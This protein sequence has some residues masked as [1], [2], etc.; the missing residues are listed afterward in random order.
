MSCG[1]TC[2]IYW[3]PCDTISTNHMHGFRDEGLQSKMFHRLY[4]NNTLTV[5]FY[6]TVG[7]TINH[8]KG[9]LVTV[10]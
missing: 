3:P 6:N 5:S 7:F 10:Y 2:E 8:H 1:G 4:N 9:N